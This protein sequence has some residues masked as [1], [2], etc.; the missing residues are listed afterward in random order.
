MIDLSKIESIR[1][2]WANRQAAEA[3][4]VE[5]LAAIDAAAAERLTGIEQTESPDYINGFRDGRA[6]R[7]RSG[8]GTDYIRGYMDGLLEDLKVSRQKQRL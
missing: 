1:H 6:G 5:R 4:E 8:C 7:S 3:A 2:W